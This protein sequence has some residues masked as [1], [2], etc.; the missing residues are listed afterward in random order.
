MPLQSPVAIF[1]YSFAST[2]TAETVLLKFWLLEILAQLG[3]GEKQIFMGMTH[4]K[5]NLQVYHMQTGQKGDL[6]FFPK[7]QASRFRH[8]AGL[9]VLLRSLPK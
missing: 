5:N 1:I 7:S 6:N 3:N 4:L 2:L 8:E 9:D